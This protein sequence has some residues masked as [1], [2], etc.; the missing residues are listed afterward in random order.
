MFFHM[1]ERSETKLK[2][3]IVKIIVSK[4]F[5]LVSSFN[6][7]IIWWIPSDKF[8]GFTTA[9]VPIT[10][11]RAH[12]TAGNICCN[13]GT[14]S[15]RE[16]LCWWTGTFDKLKHFGWCWRNS[17]RYS[18]QTQD[19]IYL[20]SLPSILSGVQV[21]RIW[22]IADNHTADSKWARLTFS[23]NVSC[24]GGKLHNGGAVFLA[25][26]V[27][28]YQELILHAVMSLLSIRSNYGLVK[29]IQLKCS[30]EKLLDHP[31]SSTL[32]HCDVCWQW[33]SCL[34]Q[35]MMQ[36]CRNL[37]EHVPTEHWELCFCR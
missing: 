5:L 15:Y 34:T 26:D 3:I 1:C 6:D 24:V 32:F 22:D 28:L 27:L 37:K 30:Q 19:V 29:Q 9:D 14:S 33:L 16:R 11:A 8:C 25:L 31:K 7:I 23:E 13:K 18:Y 20:V 12:Q 36:K 35:K 21:R 10:T 2:Q 4:P 17:S